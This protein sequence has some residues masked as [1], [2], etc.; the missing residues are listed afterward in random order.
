M[1]KEKIIDNRTRQRERI[2]LLD[3]PEREWCDFRRDYDSG[4]TFKKM[5]RNTAATP[6]Q[7]KSASGITNRALNLAA[8][9]SQPRSPHLL[10]WSILNIRRS[11]S[12]RVLL[13]KKS[14]S[15]WSVEQSLKQNPEQFVKRHISQIVSTAVPVGFSWR[16]SFMTFVPEIVP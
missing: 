6:V 1:C 13:Q 3:Y 10:I 2:P 8:R 5:P 11:S 9:G 16:T 7:L 4:M 12:V 15:A 14:G